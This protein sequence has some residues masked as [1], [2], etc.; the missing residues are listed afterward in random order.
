MAGR[1]RYQIVLVGSG[2]FVKDYAHE[3]I[4]VAQVEE[5]NKRAEALGL[6]AR[7]ELKDAKAAS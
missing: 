3:S 5:R 2:A 6:E 4:A 1:E 7:Y